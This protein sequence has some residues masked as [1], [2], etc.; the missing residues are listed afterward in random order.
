[1]VG[2]M[3]NVQR[4]MCSAHCL[5]MFYIGVKLSENISNGIRVMEQTLNYEV[6]TDRRIDVRTDGHLF[7]FGSKYPTRLQNTQQ[8]PQI[9]WVFFLDT[10]RING[11]YPIHVYP[12]YAHLWAQ[13]DGQ[14]LK[15]LDSKT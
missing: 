11:K 2:Y 12:I 4:V 3:F 14:T 1:M 6:L 5:M 8:M 10:N 9:Y 15:I 7:F 13:T